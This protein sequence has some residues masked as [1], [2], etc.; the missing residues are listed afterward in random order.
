MRSH[1]VH[2]AF[3]TPERCQF[4]RI[5]EDVEQAVAD[6]GVQ[7]GMVSRP[8]TSRPASGSTTDGLVHHQVVR[9]TT[10][11]RPD[12]G[13]WQA[14]FYAEFDGCRPKRLVIEVLGEQAP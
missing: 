4:V 1:T 2:R 11:G 14:V 12:L 9:P 3:T 8:C 6:S 7:D 10:D 13:P 5:T